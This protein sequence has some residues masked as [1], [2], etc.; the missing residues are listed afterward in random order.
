[1][2]RH[3]VLCNVTIAWS[4]L[5][6]AV[7]LSSF[8]GVCPGS[9]LPS[10]IKLLILLLTYKRLLKTVFLARCGSKAFNPSTREAHAG[11]FLWVGG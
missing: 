11:E 1:M 3:G 6:P 7:C 2:A 4:I 10:L 9:L 5:P 8:A